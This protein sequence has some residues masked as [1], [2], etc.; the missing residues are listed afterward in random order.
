MDKLNDGIDYKY[1]HDYVGY[2]VS[3]KLLTYSLSGTRF[4][5]PNEQNTQEANIA[6]HM[7]LLR[8]AKY[9]KKRVA[10]I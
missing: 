3:Q 10:N 9:G 5:T 6:E 2:F 4:Y 1:A 7:R 8:V